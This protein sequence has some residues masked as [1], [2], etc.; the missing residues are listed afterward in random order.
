MIPWPP[1]ER[2]HRKRSI[3]GGARRR[4][5]LGLA[6]GCAL[7]IA[8]IAGAV[9]GVATYEPS[10]STPPG[11]VFEALLSGRTDGGD[12]ALLA[13]QRVLDVANAPFEIALSYD[14]EAEELR[15]DALLRLPDGRLF[16]AGRAA[17]GEDGVRVVMERASESV[18]ALGLV[19]PQ[20]RLFRLGEEIVGTVE[21]GDAVPYLR[22]EGSDGVT[23]EAGCNVLS[24]Q[25]TLDPAGA[26][27]FPYLAVGDMACGDPVMARE[28]LFVDLLASVENFAIDSGRLTL[29]GGGVPLAVFVAEPKF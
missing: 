7:L 26:L 17:V 14:G 9:T 11:A 23:G 21:E 15:V 13:R 16:F 12:I 5:G 10:I 22:F 6:A 3:L 1:T 18:P 25:F 4:W 29:I 28:Q 19:G 24:G 2:R 27:T 8:P 20:W